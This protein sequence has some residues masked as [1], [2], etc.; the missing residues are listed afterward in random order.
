HQL[1]LAL[2]GLPPDAEP[3]ISTLAERLQIHH[4]SAVGLVDRLVRR[5]LVTRRRDESDQRRVLIDLTPS[6][7]A[8][9]HRLS[10]FHQ[11]ELRS[12]AGALV[13]ALVAVIRAARVRT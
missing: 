11:D 4:N 1:L 3:T 12:R 7:E 8:I 13:S 5:R 2:K 10:L 9:L 6:G